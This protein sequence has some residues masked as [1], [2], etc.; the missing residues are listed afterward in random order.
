MNRLTN[1]NMGREQ[2]QKNGNASTSDSTGANPSETTQWILG[3]QPVQPVTGY[4]QPQSV[5][6]AS[7]Q[8]GHTVGECAY[9]GCRL[10]AVTD[11][12]TSELTEYCSYEHRMWVL[13][14]MGPCQFCSKDPRRYTSVFCSNRCQ[15][16]AAHTTTS[17][18]GRPT[19]GSGGY[20]GSQGV[21]WAS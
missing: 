4:S 10:P 20:G 6:N 1:L 9:P 2:G 16:L 15:Y 3:G 17:S 12:S 14:W 19:P 11:P 21:R 5:S 8:Y 13:S 7:A 18:N